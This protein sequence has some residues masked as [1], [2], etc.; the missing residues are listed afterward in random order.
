MKKTE[1]KQIVKDLVEELRELPDGTVITSGQLLDRAGYDLKDLSEGDL[2]D[3]HD[4]LFK[5]AKANHITLDMSKH[6]NRLEGLPWNLD[7]VVRNEEAQIKCPRCGSRNTARILY[8]MPA[9]TDEFQAQLDAGR[10]Y[11]GGCCIDG[12]RTK[13]GGWVSLDPARY[14]NHCKKTFAKPAFLQ[15]HDQVISYPDIIESIEFHIGRSFGKSTTITIKKN[16][17]GALVHTEYF[18]WIPETQTEDKQISSLRWTNL[19]NRLYNELYVH[20]WK[21][22]YWNSNPEEFVM[23]GFTWELKILLNGRRRR[24]YIGG[25]N[26]VPPYWEE[27]KALFR[28]FGKIYWR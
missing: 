18:L 2:L 8:G 23:D 14:C 12:A 3:Y 26:G 10:I 9:F 27:L 17:K 24:T 5:A 25:E 19:V 11:I 20:E 4:A 21:K 16:D 28:P 1:I 6:E 22:N 7:F 13:E 15:D